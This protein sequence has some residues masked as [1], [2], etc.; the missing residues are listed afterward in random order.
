MLMRAVDLSPE[1][2]HKQNIVNV[3]WGS[4]LLTSLSAP[5]YATRLAD[6]LSGTGLILILT[7][8]LVCSLP[9][10]NGSHFSEPCLGA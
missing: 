9:A 8:L 3:S 5:G 6:M 7:R 10:L 2:C 4:E 1:L